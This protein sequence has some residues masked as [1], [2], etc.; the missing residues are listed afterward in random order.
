MFHFHFGHGMSLCASFN[1]QNI[2]FGTFWFTDSGANSA[3]FVTFMAYKIGSLLAVV[4]ICIQLYFYG[5]HIRK[6]G[7]LRDR[8]FL[9]LSRC[10]PT[11]EPQLKTPA[12]LGTPH[13]PGIHGP[14]N[15]L[16]LESVDS[17]VNNTPFS[18]AV[19]AWEIGR[20]ASPPWLVQ[21]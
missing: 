4:L 7:S 3:L 19:Y 12:H 15:E 21:Q 5:V 17:N 9:S 2:S 1:T 14:R 11:V 8:A 20:C 13:V 10:P 18:I 16:R 6:P